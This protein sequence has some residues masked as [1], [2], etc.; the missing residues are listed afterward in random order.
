MSGEDKI[1]GK[2]KRDKIYTKVLKAK[3]NPKTGRTMGT[4]R[5]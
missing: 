1:K 2:Q 3:M 5:G 4:M